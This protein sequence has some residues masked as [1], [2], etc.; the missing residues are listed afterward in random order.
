MVT[1]LWPLPSETDLS[2]HYASYYLTR[3]RD[4]ERQE[5]LVQ[6]HGGVI[7]YLAQHLPGAG[8]HSILDYGFGSGSFLRGVARQGYRAL[9]A[10]LSPQNL[11]QLHEAAVLEGLAIDLIDLSA[12]RPAGIPDVTVVTLFQV[13]EHVLDPLAL[14][15][16]LAT[17]QGDGGLIYLECP[18]DSAAWARVKDPAHR[19]L[20]HEAWGSL[21]YPEHLH[22]FNRRAIGT[23][24]EKAGYDVIECRD[25]AYRDGVHQVESEFWWPRFGEDRSGRSL[26]GLSRSFIPI[27]DKAMSFCFGAGSGLFVLGRKRPSSR[28]PVN[29]HRPAGVVHQ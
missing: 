25:Y 5:R 23:L 20:R 1:G 14:L 6:L 26:A 11:Q 3:A 21:K 4:A 13:I 16:Q 12:G 2:K 7:K 15:E 8:P 10:D 19:M 18:N 27:L 9:G 24:V 29:T 22:G 17:L 28:P